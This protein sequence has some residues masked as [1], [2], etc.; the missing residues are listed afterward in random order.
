MT[1]LPSCGFAQVRVA[2][3]ADGSWVEV[4]TVG[5]SSFTNTITGPTAFS[6]TP[7]ARVM[8]DRGLCSWGPPQAAATVAT[9]EVPATTTVPEVGMGV[10]GA[11]VGFPVPLLFVGA[12]AV[13][14]AGLNQIKGRKYSRDY[15]AQK[16][17]A[18]RAVFAL[19]DTGK[20]PIP[21]PDLSVPLIKDDGSPTW[22]DGFPKM[23]QTY[24]RSQR[25]EWTG[26]PMPWEGDTPMAPVPTLVPTPGDTPL[27]DTRDT[28]QIDPIRCCPF[29]INQPPCEG[30]KRAVEWLIYAEKSQKE[31]ITTVW[32]VS[33]NGRPGSPYQH[34]RA[35]YHGYL[36][37]WRE[38]Y[39][40][41]D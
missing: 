7:A 17:S 16:D 14:A 32:G 12:I 24:P 1:S 27:S 35:R 15:E 8:L 20:P 30:E 29:D 4:F 19:P 37:A 39:G 22:P 5:D 34:A 10:S 3:R 41:R 28:P 25:D 18:Y 6:R 31:I 40:I 21:A 13:V 11:G 26:E 36:Q 38:K 2:Q 33:K 23:V 9:A